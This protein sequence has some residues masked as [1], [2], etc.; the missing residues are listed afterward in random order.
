MVFVEAAVGAIAGMILIFRPRSRF[1]WGL[2]LLPAVAINLFVA[3]FAFWPGSDDYLVR[4]PF[5]PALTLPKLSST[6][7]YD[8]GQ[9]GPFSV[10]SCTYGSGSD[11][12]R[13]EYGAQAC[14]TAPTVD[15][16]ASLPILKSASMDYYTWFWGFDFTS[17]PLNGRVWAPVTP[18]P[19]PLV[20][21]PRTSSRARPRGS[22]AG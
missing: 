4:Q 14:W 9:T 12:R 13:P 2:A 11:I 8:P 10:Q 1:V 18:N 17:L 3:I 16:K 22:A 21:T 20:H 19:A 6:G 5:S 15:A 7:L